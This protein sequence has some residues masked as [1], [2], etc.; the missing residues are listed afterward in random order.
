[1][2]LVNREERAEV[3]DEA[4]SPGD[5][6]NDQDG[7]L[8]AVGVGDDAGENG[9]EGRARVLDK[10]FHRLRR[11]ADLGDGHIINGGDDVGRGE[12]HED[13]GEAHENKELIRR[14]DGRGDG[15]REEDRAEQN[16]RAGDEDASLFGAL[17]GRPMTMTGHNVL[18]EKTTCVGICTNAAKL[19]HAENLRFA[20][21]R[22]R[23]AQVLD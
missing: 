16:A 12:R 1:M 18:L 17:D 23:S 11:G 21:L 6:G 14:F 22:L 19:Y 15:Q 2:I 9:S 7:G 8:E 10:V 20:M 13:G 3:E 4:Q 5:G